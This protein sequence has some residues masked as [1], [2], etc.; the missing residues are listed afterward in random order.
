MQY[1]EDLHYTDD[2]AWQSAGK[3]L[4]PIPAWAKFYV[5]LGAAVTHANTEGIRQVAALSLP[6][7]AYCSPLVAAGAIAQQAS[8]YQAETTPVLQHF[9]K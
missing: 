8:Q 9:E 3:G 1:F 7:R 4:F 5:D 6:T 2:R